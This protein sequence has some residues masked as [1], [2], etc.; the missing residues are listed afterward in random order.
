MP[1]ELAAEVQPIAVLPGA[2][3]G[4]QRGDQFPHPFH[5]PVE[6]CAVAALDLGPDLGAEPEGEPA[7]A[8]QLVVVGLMGELNRIAR[9]RDGDVGHQ[10]QPA[11]R[12]RQGQRREHVV[13]ALEGEH[14]GS[15]GVTQGMSAPDG[16]GGPEQGGEHF[17]GPLTLERFRRGNRR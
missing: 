14:P 11:G 7:R 16:V 4:P 9:E 2:E 6:G 13:R 1:V 3:D 5:R 10:I 15:P 8:E 12:R 17:H